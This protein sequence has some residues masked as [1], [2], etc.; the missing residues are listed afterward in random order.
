VVSRGAIVVKLGGSLAR[1]RQ[2]ARW[3][4]ALR[5][6]KSGVIIVPGGG[7]FADCVRD[8][9]TYMRFSDA[10]AHRM[11][12]LGMEQYAIACASSFP[13]VLLL[14]DEAQLRLIGE[15]RIA[16][17]LPSRMALGADD[18][19]QNWQVT[20]DSLAAWLTRRLELQA[21]VLLKSVDAKADP[22]SARA[23]VE[24]EIVDPFFARFATRTNVETRIAGPGALA[25]AGAVFAA[26]HLP[27]ARVVAHANAHANA[28]A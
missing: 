28:H 18:L 4:E 15:G 21:L 16:F 14:T 12:L 8:A 17:W 25:G 1:G 20:S 10:A 26:G 23:L 22:I 9:Q 13:D 19:P 3:I 27:G 11:A 2:F 7:P 5:R 24:G 6:Y